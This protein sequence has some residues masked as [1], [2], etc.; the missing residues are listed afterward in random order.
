MCMKKIIQTAVLLLTLGRVWAG[1]IIIIDPQAGSPGAGQY[2]LE[3]RS[4]SARVSIND[5]TASTAIDQVFY[6]AS[7]ARLEGWFIFP[8]PKGSGIKEFMMD[9]NG[10]M[11]HAELLDAT[12]AKAI[13]EDIV[14]RY[15]DPALLEYAGADLFRV[16]IF[17][18][19]PRSEKKTS[20]TIT[21]TLPKMG[22]LWEYTL[23]VSSQ[24][25]SGQQLQSIQIAAD[26]ESAYPLK[27]V[28]SPSHEV[29]TERK[30]D[31]RTEVR[32][33]AKNHR[34]DNDFRL[35]VS[36]TGDKLGVSLLTHKEA[37]EDGFFFLDLNPGYLE[38]TGEDFAKDV[39]FVIDV[40]GSM[41]G[42]KIQQA[43]N[44]LLF[45][46]QK[47]QPGDRFEVI[48]FSTDAEALFG[49]RVPNTKEN[50]LKAQNFVKNLQELGGTN[51]DEAFDQALAEK[52]DPARPHMVL[53]LTDGKPTVGQTDGDALATEIK[54]NT[55]KDTRIFS[56]GIGHDLHTRLLEKISLETKGYHT[57]IAPE[58][59]LEL[60]VADIYKKLSRPV[61]TDIKIKTE[62]D[63]HVSQIYPKELP[64]LFAGSSLT[65]FGRYDKPGAVK[66]TVT[67]K[68][69]GLPFSF[70]KS[71]IVPAET[72][73]HEFIPSLWATRKI[74]WMLEEIR[75]RGESEELKS[76]IVVLARKYGVITPYTSYLIM[77]D[78]QQQVPVVS[79][80]GEE[81]PPRRP[82]I[83]NQ[84]T[85][86]S[87]ERMKV[88]E[89]YDD[90]KAISGSGST[91]TGNEVRVMNYADNVQATSPGYARM[92][93]KGDS[94]TALN[95][96]TLDF[97]NAG[98]R[99]FY[100]DGNA[101][102]EAEPAKAAKKQVVKFGSVEYFAL[103][104]NM[105]EAKEILALG[106]N[107]NFTYRGVN[108]I[109]TE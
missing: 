79:R 67:G 51:I 53:F 59:D 73:K 99:A 100:F 109:V 94:Q 28:Y 24:L 60:K 12:K 56:I 102:N 47:L 54:T 3:C 90:L 55:D 40:S 20:I 27:T 42:Q 46:L 45:C 101:W 81:I 50:N 52:A 35:Y 86:T 63:V 103:V 57:Y 83:F 75:L 62:G 16:R 108:I 39:T 37:G 97:R 8:V 87:T 32:F 33:S 98:G 30:G 58:E 13:Y 77:E 31:K 7:S 66:I 95:N 9:V 61:L 84:A 78:E 15:K 92:L 17:P 23:P 22:D 4:L 65:L 96:R 44:A 49:K 26:V 80:P 19:E 36:S 38:E 91:R 88:Q 105:P 76:E 107:V 48:R 89:E 104:Q 85:T 10:K 72:G 74:G 34:P 68:V 5:G 11:T 25:K 41:A 106:R 14:R 29:V 6:N 93:E 71:G 18:I 2:M 21:Q 82:V 1:G 64:D 70:A 69:R 43:K